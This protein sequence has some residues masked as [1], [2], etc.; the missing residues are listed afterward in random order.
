MQLGL[1]ICF[2][3]PTWRLCKCAV[4]RWV[5]PRYYTV[6]P[7]L[8]P[9]M[10]PF[11]SHEEQSFCSYSPCSHLNVFDIFPPLIPHPS[12]GGFSEGLD[13][14][15]FFFKRKHAL[16]LRCSVNGLLPVIFFRLF[17]CSASM[18]TIGCDYYRSCTMTPNLNCSV[19]YAFILRVEALTAP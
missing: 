10:N 5:S 17:L 8:L 14:F 15:R 11:I 7:M 1:C 18:G 19:T 13:A 2:G 3:V 16:L 9:S 12:S 4:Q 6:D